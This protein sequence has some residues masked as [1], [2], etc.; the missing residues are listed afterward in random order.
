M[1][2]SENDFIDNNFDEDDG[3]FGDEDEDIPTRPTR[4]LSDRELDSGDDEG[5]S[6]RAQQRNSEEVEYEAER[7]ARVLEATLWRHPIPNP[8]DGQLNTL[9]VPKFLS[10]EPRAYESANF[11]PPSSDHHSETKSVNFS[12]YNVALSTIR[13]RID[14]KSGNMES[15]TVM[16]KWSDG[17]MTM[18]IGDKHYQLQTKPM[19]PPLD[20]KPYQEIQDSH[21]YL[22]TPSIASQL[23]LLVGH[24]TN[25]CTVL[26]NKDIEDD[27]LEKLQK[28]LA[29]ATRGGSKD[30]MG[31]PEL[32]TKTEDPELQKKKAEIAEKERMRAQRRRELAAE[33]Q[34][35]QRFHGTGRG[36]LNIDDLEGRSSRRDHAVGRKTSKPRRNRSSYDSEEESNVVRNREDEYDKEDD[37]LADSD[38][39]I[40][41]TGDEQDDTD[42]DSERGEPKQKKT[43]ISKSAAERYDT[44]FDVDADADADADTDM[45]AEAD[46]EDEDLPSQTNM[47]LAARGRKRH[48][49]ED[50]EDD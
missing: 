26:P 39:D 45:D 20:N 2:R 38:E 10:I 17:S 34:N 42:E 40:E 30:D 41:E 37:F 22:A 5:R 4:E 50:D 15:N 3:L 48:I 36:G 43:K 28:S 33:K 18:S 35:L 14:Q 13:Y 32:I 27:A 6:D 12:A 9:R 47:D 31:G 49:I 29:A 24:M 21:T 19:A 11:V 44:N 7:D 46:L 1:A 23:L 25:Q 8:S 16:H